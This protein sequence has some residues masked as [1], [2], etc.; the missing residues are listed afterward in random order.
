[1]QEGSFKMGRQERF[2]LETHVVRVIPKGANGEIDIPCTTQITADFQK[3]VANWLD[4]TINRVVCRVKRI[5]GGFG[6]IKQLNTARIFFL[7]AFASTGLNRPV[8]CSLTREEDMSTTGNFFILFHPNSLSFSCSIQI[9][10]HFVQ[11]TD[12]TGCPTG[13]LY[14]NSGNTM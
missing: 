11:Q 3:L 14:K 4:V 6:E 5:G 2:Y 7:A 9:S 10:L 1:M 12:C 13:Q 8:R